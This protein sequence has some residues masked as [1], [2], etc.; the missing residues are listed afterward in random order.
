[1]L[2]KEECLKI[3]AKHRTD[4]IMRF[5]CGLRPASRR[6]DKGKGNGKREK[7]NGQKKEKGRK[8]EQREKGKK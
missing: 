2:N 5:L 8:E 3:I 1:M 7:M 6:G 4:E